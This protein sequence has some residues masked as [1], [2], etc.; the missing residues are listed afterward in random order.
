MVQVSC[1][2]RKYEGFSSQMPSPSCG[3]RRNIESITI[4]QGKEV[5]E[6]VVLDN[7]GPSYKRKKFCGEEK[8]GEEERKGCGG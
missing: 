2:L 3:S 1:R 4:A 6:D 7:F 5:T 8:R